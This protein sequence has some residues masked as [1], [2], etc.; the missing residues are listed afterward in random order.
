MKRELPF[1]FGCLLALFSCHSEEDVV[2][3]QEDFQYF[4]LAIGNRWEYEPMHTAV[5]G[6]KTAV[7]DITRSEI[8][9]GKEYFVMRR[10]FETDYESLTDSVLYRVDSRGNVFEILD[11]DKKE[12]N[13]FRLVATDGYKWTID[14]SPYEDLV[15]T[16][17]YEDKVVNNEQ[18]RD[19][20]DFYFN[21]PATFDEEHSYV[22]AKGIGI[23]EHSNFWGINYKLKS[24]SLVP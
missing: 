22:L 19:C 4:P 8:R 16:V 17:T 23:I 11:F 3:T 14:G 5:P 2:A 9:A 20:K 1:V 7:F 12:R 24:V 6:F 13:R 10:T 18:L 21:A 15:V